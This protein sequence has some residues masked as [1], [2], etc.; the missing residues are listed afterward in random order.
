MKQTT[1]LISAILISVFAYSQNSGGLAKTLQINPATL[2]DANLKS[3]S[4][5]V[6][7]IPYIEKYGQ[8]YRSVFDQNSGIETREYF[9][10]LG[11]LQQVVAKKVTPSG[12]DIATH[13]EYEGGK[14][15]RS[16]LPAAVGS[17]NNCDFVTGFKA[18]AISQYS[19]SRPFVETANSGFSVA[20]TRAGAD[21]ANKTAEM[22]YLANGAGEVKMFEFSNGQIRYV[23][24]YPANELIKI[25]VKDEDEKTAWQF[26]DRE[27]KTV[28]TLAKDDGNPH[29][30]YYVYDDFGR[31]RCVLPP[32]AADKFSTAGTEFS[33]SADAVKNLAYFYKYDKFGN[34][35]EKKIPN[36]EPILYVYDKA[37]RLI[38]CQDGNQ[39]SENKW[40]V[41]KYDAYGRTVYTG[42]L[43]TGRS[44]EQLRGFLADKTVIEEPTAWDFKAG[45]SVSDM[46][47]SLKNY[48]KDL[49]EK[50]LLFDIRRRFLKYTLI[51]FLDNVGYTCNFFAGEITP[52]TV[53]YYDDYS[54]LNILPAAVKTEL[55]FDADALQSAIL[56]AN[57]VL[58]RDVSKGLPTGTRT[59]LLDN[60][61]DYTVS[62]TYYNWLGQPI[63]T[64]STNHLGGYDIASIMYDNSGNP[65]LTVKK[66]SANINGTPSARTEEYVYEYDNALRLKKTKYKL[67]NNPTVVL[68]ENTYDELGRITQKKR[69]NSTDTEKFSYNIQNWLTK[70]TSGGFEESLDYSKAGNINSQSWKN[71]N[72]RGYQYN[73]QYDGLNRILHG[74]TTTGCN[75]HFTYDKNGNIETLVR[76]KSG[77]VIDDLQMY[78]NGNQLA[79]IQEQAQNHNYSGQNSLKEYIQK[80]DGKFEYD[81]N[82]NLIKDTD[83]KILSIRYNVLNL[84]SEIIFE[85]GNAIFN[86]YAADARKLSSYYVSNINQAGSSANSVSSILAAD[87]THY[88][89][90]IEYLLKINNGAVTLRTARIHNSEGYVSIYNEYVYYRRDH[91]GNN[92]EVWSA[93]TNRTDQI[94]NY[95][96]SGLP[97]AYET[98]AVQP[99]MYNGKEFVE[100]DYDVF[101]YGFRGYYAA[102]GRFTSIDPMSEGTYAVST[103]A[104]AS[105]NPVGNID[106]MGLFASNSGGCTP[107]PTFG[108]GNAGNPYGNGAFGGIED[109]Y[110]GCYDIFDFL[111]KGSSL[112]EFFESQLF[113]GSGGGGSDWGTWNLTVLNGDGEIIY[114]ENNGDDRILM[115]LDG[116]F[117]KGDDLE[118]MILIGYE[119]PYKGFYEKGY[120]N[121]SQLEWFQFT[122]L[123]AN[124]SVYS[125]SIEQERAFLMPDSTDPIAV[126]LRAGYEDGYNGKKKSIWMAHLQAVFSPENAAMQAGYNQGY[127]RGKE[128]KAKGKRSLL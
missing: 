126:G 76:S 90:N 82:G 99:Y 104:Y 63:Q 79:E 69:H 110:E 7:I 122:F 43:Q 35:I 107:V 80:G 58:K 45:A 96:P 57:F 61:G 127:E 115:D 72:N 77:T 101:D 51:P 15:I 37:Q 21:W 85:N 116:H 64:R 5:R 89:G 6:K 60:S 95:Y 108:S 125:I 27:G 66:H 119:L 26:T 30:T 11:R 16:W 117:E 39:R 34:C 105:N 53:N 120:K 44:Y 100:F 59:Y 92:R 65:T 8:N 36:S 20:Q 67:N 103:Y 14:V 1:L 123:P 52:L 124:T 62:A 12:A 68:A 128:D 24:D 121:G 10:G 87:A 28:L 112:Y 49:T 111:S 42:I 41:I 73:Y 13:Y 102:A 88:A 86:V 48:R 98:A 70:K 40:T 97:W 9:D 31:L 81:A 25:Q 74:A 118:G 46:K 78:Y 56:Q 93:S 29:E 54:F 84:P 94:T 17:N 33:D 114:Y 109:Y 19:D 2:P 32:L 55:Q 23:G 3:F 4:E 75:E 47:L 106:V 18:E 22:D 71:S 83:R 38:L 91:L 50:E 113:G